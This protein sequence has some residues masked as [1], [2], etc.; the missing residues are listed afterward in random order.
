MKGRDCQELSSVVLVVHSSLALSFWTKRTIRFVQVVFFSSLA[1][2]IGFVNVLI[3]FDR[4][5]SKRTIVSDKIVVD[6]TLSLSL[7]LL[8]LQP[9]NKNIVIIVTSTIKQTISHQKVFV[10]SFCRFV[11]WPLSFRFLS[12]VLSFVRSIAD[13][14]AKQQRL[15][16]RLATLSQDKNRF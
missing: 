14:N 8:L 5:V 2:V 7:S 3:L 6:S 16:S 12:L 4:C 10:F 15:L 1:S 11:F 13:S 9:K